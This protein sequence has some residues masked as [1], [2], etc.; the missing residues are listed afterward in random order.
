MYLYFMYFKGQFSVQTNG[1][2]YIGPDLGYKY[3]T[4][5]IYDFD[6]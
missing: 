1:G 2:V 5:Q 4:I 3:G 6:Q